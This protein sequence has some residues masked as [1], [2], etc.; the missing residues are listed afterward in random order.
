MEQTLGYSHVVFLGSADL[1]RGHSLAF[2][3]YLVIGCLAEDVAVFGI[4]LVT[5]GDDAVVEFAIHNFEST[6]AFCI[7]TLV[8]A[9]VYVDEP[10]LLGTGAEDGA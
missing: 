6:I 5:G 3:H 8:F 1:A 7:F 10:L 9:D 2:F 4:P